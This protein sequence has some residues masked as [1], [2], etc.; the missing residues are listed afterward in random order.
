MR[1]WSYIL[2]TAQDSI[3]KY[4]QNEYY[5]AF[6]EEA[7]RERAEEPIRVR[8]IP[9][10][11]VRM[12]DGWRRDT[13]KEARMTEKRRFD[14]LSLEEQKAERADKR[15][16]IRAASSVFTS[17]IISLCPYFLCVHIYWAL[18]YLV[19]ITYIIIF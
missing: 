2:L 8:A 5:K 1:R 4:R 14:A 13:A 19:P 3:S 9:N 12:N 7:A 15:R 17:L 6:T 16:R 10:K 11:P 18:W